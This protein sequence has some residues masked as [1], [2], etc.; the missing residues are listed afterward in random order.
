MTETEGQVLRRIRERAGVPGVEMARLTGL[1]SAKVSHIEHGRRGVTR[2]EFDAWLLACRASEDERAD[3]EA[4]RIR[5]L[6]LHEADVA[7]IQQA[8]T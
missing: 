3:A 1:T 6:G 4:A 5:A 2:P 7:A 8:G